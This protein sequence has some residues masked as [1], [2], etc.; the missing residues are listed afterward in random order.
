MGKAEQ[1]VSG[2]NTKE[3]PLISISRQLAQSVRPLSFSAPVSYVY[4]VLDYAAAAHE[5]Y[6]AKYGHG[7]KKV[8]FFGMNPGP[9]GMMQTGVPF[10]DVKMVRD[11]LKIH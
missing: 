3:M 2:T 8:V 6:L 7:P 9:F 1:R 4:R 11:F 10:G 5:Q